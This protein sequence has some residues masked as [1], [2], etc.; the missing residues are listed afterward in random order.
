MCMYRNQYPPAGSTSTRY[1][2]CAGMN[3]VHP[4][5]H[6]Q[7]CSK[8]D[9]PSIVQGISNVCAAAAGLDA[10][11]LQSC[12]TSDLGVS[13]LKRSMN[14]SSRFPLS[15]MRKVEPQW[16]MVDGPES[17]S[18]ENGGWNTCKAY[19]DKTS[20]EDW[21]HCSSESWALHL[22]SRVCKSAGISSCD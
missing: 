5:L 4:L 19:F 8:A 22:R 10:N 13:L 16:I 1:L 12:A 20:C 7:S 11:E 21:G 3:P 2:E 14:R 17:C 6:N 15:I 9:F 18:A